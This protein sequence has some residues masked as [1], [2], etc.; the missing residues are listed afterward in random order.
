MAKRRVLGLALDQG[1]REQPFPGPS[2]RTLRELGNGSEPSVRGY[3]EGSSSLSLA[4]HVLCW[5]VHRIDAGSSS[6]L[7]RSAPNGSVEFVCEVGGRPL[8]VGPQTGPLVR[9]LSPGATIVSLRLRPESAAAVLG[10]QAYELADQVV[11]V[12]DVLPATRFLGERIAAEPKRAVAA[13]EAT[14]GTQVARGTATDRSVAFGVGRMAAQP[15]RVSSVAASLFVSER[16]LRRRFKAAVGLSPKKLER[17]LRFQRFL[18]HVHTGGWRTPGLARSAV[19][20]GYADQ[21]HLTRECVRLSGVPPAE[22]IRLT[23][24]CCSG[25]HDHSPSFRSLFRNTGKRWGRPA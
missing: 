1:A 12:E 20:L 17:V 22:L 18:A 11:P 23:D 8:V 15:I 4:A 10:L 16:E 2:P 13:L 7:H 24:L 21:A 5:S 14:V 6:Y 3:V 25:R 9:I 19:A